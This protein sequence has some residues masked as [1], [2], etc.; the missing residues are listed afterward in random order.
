MKRLSD[1][2]EREIVER[3]V[4]GETARVL[5]SEFGISGSTVCL[6][7]KHFGRSP[8]LK[9]RGQGGDKK[10]TKAQRLEIVRRRMEGERTSDLAKEFGVSSSNVSQLSRK[11]DGDGI[12]D[13]PI[14]ADGPFIQP[15]F[16]TRRAAPPPNAY[17]D[18]PVSRLMAGR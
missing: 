5:G 8:G 1:V 11:M 10:L 17:D 3:Y 15:W 18:I 6:L 13:L 2:R 14:T 12:E 16:P 7:A 9:G 4:D